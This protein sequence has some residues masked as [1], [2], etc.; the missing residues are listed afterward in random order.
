[1]KNNHSAFPIAFLAILLF[2]CSIEEPLEPAGSIIPDIPYIIATLQDDVLTEG[3]ET[4]TMFQYSN[5]KLK[6]SWTEG[7]EIAIS[8]KLY[9]CINAGTYRVTD[10]EN[11]V[12]ERITEIGATSSTYGVFYP[13]SKI[14][15]TAQYTRF[16]YEGQVQRADDPQGTWVHTTV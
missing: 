5:K 7:D 8:P 13:A 6:A 15:S 1:M 16:H 2:S 14:K 3:P 9:D 11:G 12:F 10:P 4:K